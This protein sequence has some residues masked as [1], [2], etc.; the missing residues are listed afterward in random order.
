[1]SSR[2]LAFGTLDLNGYRPL[3][4]FEVF[5]RI[6]TREGPNSWTSQYPSVQNLLTHLSRFSKSTGSRENYLNNLKRFC[7]YTQIGPDQLVLMEKYQVEVLIQTY[8]DD[9]A[10]KDRSRTY[11]NACLKRLR[12]FFV[13]NGFKNDKQLDLQTFFQPA[14]YRSR[15]EYIPT[16]NE[17]YLMAEAASNI[18]DR[19]IILALWSTGL[20]VSTFCA[21]NIGDIR[22]DLESDETNLLVPVY[23]EMKNRV[24]DACKGEISYFSFTSTEATRAIK[25]YLAERTNAFGAPRDTDP[26]FHSDWHLW[27]KEERQGKRIGRRGIGLI[28]KKTAE[29]AG[30]PQYSHITP[31][32]L[33][34]S[35]QTVLISPTTDGSRLD[36]GVQEYLFGHILPR[37]QD[38]YFD[39]TKPDVLKNEYSKLDFRKTAIAPISRDK[40]VQL[41][42]LESHFNDGWVYVATVADGKVIVR[43]E[44]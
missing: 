1:L 22:R 37:S 36:K 12:T 17:L 3:R 42:E 34:K 38:P 11:L 18:R 2:K 20:R 8:V 40:L 5:F 13:V 32:C 9:L 21:L 25:V 30:I 39:K 7:Q 44:N 27:R 41:S 35:F 28:I 19:A 6:P 26:L 14:R 43:R 4:E 33:R 31:H 15:P 23:P 29:L 10:R 24:P 16:K